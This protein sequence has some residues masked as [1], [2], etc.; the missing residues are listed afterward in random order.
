MNILDPHLHFNDSLD[1][2][3]QDPDFMATFY[4]KFLNASPD[5]AEKFSH[6]DMDQQRRMVLQSFHIIMASFHNPAAMLGKIANRHGPDDLDI[7][8]HLYDTWLDSLIHAVRTHDPKF[9]EEVEFSWRAVFRVGIDYI[10]K[11][12]RA[13]SV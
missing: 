12:H 13:K 1:R 11:Q 6:T 7:S 4:D 8:P 5:I 9:S 10:V 2:V 3:R